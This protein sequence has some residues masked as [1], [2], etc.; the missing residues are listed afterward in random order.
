MK[1][2]AWVW[3]HIIPI[4]DCRALELE[5]SL[6]SIW[7]AR[8]KL[9]WVS[10]KRGKRGGRSLSLRQEAALCCLRAVILQQSLGAKS[11]PYC[12]CQ[13]TKQTIDR[14]NMWLLFGD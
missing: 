8:E 6:R 11:P 12:C 1:S 2:P 14:F 13:S 4:Y 3:W 5:A 9:E 10:K 7:E